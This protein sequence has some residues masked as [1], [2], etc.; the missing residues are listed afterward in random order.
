M[1]M[2][3]HLIATCLVAVG[4]VGGELR[5]AAVTVRAAMTAV[6][7]IAT[8]SVSAQSP[9]Q[10]GV[11]PRAMVERFCRLDWEGG[12]LTPAGTADA[13]PLLVSPYTWSPT[14]R[15]RVVDSYAVRGRD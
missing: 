15:F 9:A 3:R 10:P 8:L 4:A 7:I 5:R 13:E 11:S 14:Q 6:L 2:T 12:L 1:R